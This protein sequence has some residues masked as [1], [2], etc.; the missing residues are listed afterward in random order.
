MRE[1]ERERERENSS[2]L[3]TQEM[4]FQKGRQSSVHVPTSFVTQDGQLQPE[5]FASDSRVTRQDGEAL[6]K[7]GKP[8][9]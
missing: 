1:R 9:F 2:F 6:T 8:F 3:W 7:N 5:L 4:T